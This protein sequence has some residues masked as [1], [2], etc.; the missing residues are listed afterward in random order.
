MQT[1]FQALDVRLSRLE[2]VARKLEEARS[3]LEKED[4]RVTMFVDDHETL[5]GAAHAVLLVVGLA[6]EEERSARL[7]SQRRHALDVQA[8]QPG[9][10]W[11]ILFHLRLLGREGVVCSSRTGEVRLMKVG[12][13]ERNKG[14]SLDKG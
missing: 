2:V 6:K 12:R 9:V 3:D 7:R 1:R 11:G 4:M 8:L 10:H 14:D 13:L 5:G